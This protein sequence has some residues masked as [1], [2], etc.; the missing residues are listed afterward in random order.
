MGAGGSA[1]LTLAVIAQNLTLN[2]DV[3]PNYKHMFGQ[4]RGR[5]PHSE[6]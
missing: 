1:R 2:S 6:I 3:S 5:L 4:F